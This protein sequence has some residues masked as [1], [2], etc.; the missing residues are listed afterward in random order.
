M[1]KGNKTELKKH[2]DVLLIDIQGDVTGFSESSLNEAYKNANEQGAGSILLKFEQ[3]AYINSAGIAIIIQILAESRRNKQK[4]GIT[5]IS[6]H[7]KK[8]FGLVGIT[9]FAKI[10]N[11]IDEG[12]SGLSCAK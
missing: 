1:E 7:F 2:N 9:K 6:E 5:G 8:I 10:Y 11:T 4:I 3:N 12:I